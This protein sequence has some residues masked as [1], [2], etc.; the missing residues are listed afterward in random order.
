V[1]QVVPLQTVPNQTLQVQLGGQA[2]TLNVAQSDYGLFMDVLVGSAL[3][4]AGVPCQNMNRVVRDIYLGFIGDLCWFDS[5]GSS[6][7]TYTDFG[8]RYFLIFLSPSDLPSG[9]G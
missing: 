5:Q 1:A 3:I 4:V 8:I 7:P 6:D 9:E 2:C